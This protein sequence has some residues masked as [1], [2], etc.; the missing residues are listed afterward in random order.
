MGG[1]APAMKG[2]IKRKEGTSRQLK[3]VEC[4]LWPSSCPGQV[5]GLM[6][7]QLS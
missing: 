3:Q 4:E 6:L 5:M 1:K 2:V 7:V